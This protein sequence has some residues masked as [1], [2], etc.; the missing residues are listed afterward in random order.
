MR[1][2]WR[3]WRN[4]FRHRVGA[5]GVAV[6]RDRCPATGPADAVRWFRQAVAVSSLWP[7]NYR[8]PP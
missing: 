4:G 3:A 7:S 6:R 2:G 5:G 8:S 1:P